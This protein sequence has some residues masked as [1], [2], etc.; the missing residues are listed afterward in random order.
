[1]ALSHTTALVVFWLA[2]NTHGVR[3]LLV[4]KKAAMYLIRLSLFFAPRYWR[5]TEPKIEVKIKR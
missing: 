2:S 4:T 5:V 1:M 3:D